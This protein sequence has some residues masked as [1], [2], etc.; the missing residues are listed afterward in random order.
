MKFRITTFCSILLFFFHSSILAQNTNYSDS[1]KRVDSLL[2]KGL[3]RSALD[4]VNDIRSQ[5]ISEE[6]SQQNIKALAEQIKLESI[7][8]EKSDSLAIRMLETEIDKAKSP[9]KQILSSLLASAYWNYYQN[10]RYQILNRT[11]LEEASTDFQT[12]DARTFQGE[13]ICLY[14]ESIKEKDAL[15]KLPVRDFE[16]IIEKAKDSELYR[17]SLYDLL[18]HKALDY[19]L[20]RQYGIIDPIETFD[21]DFEPLMVSAEDFQ[22]LNWDNPEK[23]AREIRTFGLFQELIAEHKGKNDKAFIDVEL[24]RLKYIKNHATGDEGEKEAAFKKELEALAKVAPKEAITGE[25]LFEIASLK[26]N[27]GSK[28]NADEGED[29]RWEKKEALE[30]CEKIIQDYP[31]TYGGSQAENLK[32]SI[33]RP[34]L[35]LSMEEVYFPN[36]PL[37]A[38]IRYKNPESVCFR[39]VELS[40][41]LSNTRN[42][43]NY[44]KKLLK[45]GRSV[46]NWSIALKNE[47]DYQD[48]STEIAIDELKNGRYVLLA[49]FSDKFELD[50]DLIQ[51]Q[52]FQVSGIAYF[53]QSGIE[54][55]KQGMYIRDR[56][57]GAALSGAKLQVYE[58][59]R[60]AEKM[61][62]RG[63][64]LTA[65]KEGFVAFDFQE[66]YGRAQYIIKHKKD[67]LYS[68]KMYRYRGRPYGEERARQVIHFFTDRKIYRPGQTIYFKAIAMESMRNSHMLKKNHSLEIKFNDVNGQ[69]IK[70]LSLK[71]N[72]F[73]SVQGSFT[74]PN[75]GLTGRMSI[76]TDG[77]YTDL[78]VEEYK[79]PKFEVTFDP[80]EGEYSLND[81]VEVKGF[82]KAFAGSNIDGAKVSYRVVRGANFPYWY[83]GWRGGRMYPRFGSEKEIT[84]G[85]TETD[86]EGKFSIS[87]TAEADKKID[88][89]FLPVFYYRLYADVVDISGE[90]HSAQAYVQV[91]YTSLDLS[92]TVSEVVWQG[93]ADS[94]QIN[95]V[96]HNGSPLSAKGTLTI[97]QLEAPKQIFRTRKWPAPDQPIMS[98]AEFTKNFPNT[99]YK[100]EDQVQSWPKTELKTRELDLEGMTQV[101]IDDL[102]QGAKNGKYEVV[103]TVKDPSGEELKLQRFFSYEDPEDKT[104]SVP[105]VLDAS[106]ENKAY[107]PG[108]TAVLNLQS[109]VKRLWVL[110]EVTQGG[111]VLQRDYIRLKGKKGEKIDIVLKEEH[112][113]GLGV[114]VYAI[115]NNEFKS[116]R[117]NISIPWTNKQLK[118]S[119]TTFRSKLSPGQEEEWRLKIS[120]PKGEKVAA[121]MV[122]SLYDE[123]LDEFRS[124]YFG[125]S[126]YGSN[127]SSAAWNV[128][129]GFAW[130]NSYRISDLP[131]PP[132]KYYNARDYDRLI[133]I[134]AFGYG[135]GGRMMMK[136]RA[137]GARS[138][139]NDQDLPVA[140]M[141]APSRE[142]ETISAPA[143]DADKYR[144]SENADFDGTLDLYEK[145]GEDD[146]TQAEETGAKPTSEV[147]IRTNLQETAF[148]FPQL[149]TNAEGE[150]VLSFKIPEALTRWKFLGLA[151]T[152]DLKV[153]TIGGNTVTQKE[154]MVFPNMPRFLREGDKLA[155]TAKISNLSEKALSGNAEVRL[156]DAL[157]MQPVESYFDLNTKVQKFEVKEGQS[158]VV[159][160]EIEVPEN[161]QAVVTQV[162]AS[163]GEFSDGEENVL[164]ILKN[165]MLVTESLPLAV[166]GE[167]QK[168]YTFKKLANSGASET[169]K[170]HNLTLEFSSNPAWYAVQ[171]LPYLMEYPHECTEQIFSRFY[172]NALATHVANSS[173]R[174]QQIFNQWKLDAQKLSKD[175]GALL[176][177]LEKNQEL[178]AVLLEETP[179]VLNA[180][181]ESERKRRIGLLFDLNRMQSE[182]AKANKQLEERQNG[183][184]AFSWFP[185]MRDSRYITQLIV[186]GIGHMD[187]L[188]VNSG[189]PEINGI[190][191]RGLAYLDNTIREDYQNLK[192]HK[193][194]LEEDHLG[195]TQIQ[196]LYARSFYP[197]VPV[198]P[199]NVEAYNYYAGQAKK[200]WLS[201]S[202]Y[203][204]GMLALFNFRSGDPKVSGDIL[205]SLKENAVFNEELGMYWKDATSGWYW[206]QAPIERH[207]LLLEAFQEAG[208]DEEAVEELK[209]WLLKNKQTND[210]KTT[211]ATVAAIN[212]LLSSGTDWLESSELVEIV[213]GG[214]NIDP[215]TRP[216][217]QV[218][219][220]TGYFMTSWA[221]Q[222]INAE[223]ATISLNKK[224]KGIAWGAMYWQ[225]FEQLDKITFAETPLSLKKQL[226][227]K[228][229][230]PEGPK[231]IAISDSSQIERGDKI[232]VRVE[233]RVD[234]AM[235]YVHMKDMRAAAFEPTET[236][237]RYKYKAGLGWYQSTRDV[238][239]HFFFDYLPKGT[240]VFEYD[241]VATQAGDFSNGI[242]S[243][244]S[245]YA[246]EFTSHSEGIRVQVK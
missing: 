194:N 57:T 36:A 72:D 78:S 74:A 237:S 192:K 145:G 176:S 165:S 9:E 169:L 6:N 201:K 162:I 33:E 199:K 25:V 19:L 184:G 45:E 239:T 23:L 37:L 84:N 144:D 30:L 125:M 4:L 137:V 10:N 151:H 99:V 91:A 17:P 212:A 27:L 141:P 203:M 152:K 113:G 206:Y 55:G 106:L 98:K 50:K 11:Q 188:G 121:E 232:T 178:K 166:R 97:N 14:E 100:D 89:K 243:I 58:E 136:S 216:D 172:A 233:L 179:W 223:K 43:S 175:Q 189:N 40:E 128:D 157:T 148:F 107:E 210:W 191:A 12:W 111:K 119:W 226:F 94:L 83:R 35:E 225:Y 245:M 88:R 96:N 202:K 39:I 93:K 185:G 132:R 164:P 114:G 193:A 34:S 134:S 73:G 122:A 222:E 230:S 208:K 204:Q 153:G 198:A 209:I 228:K 215:K 52:E 140:S 238:A 220:G 161:V 186:T 240:H 61:K 142:A 242:T 207:S 156:L 127:Y 139:M 138:R 219:A 115:Y 110:Y 81:E 79:R 146:M 180:R 168:T 158:T 18:A 51:H 65:N 44:Y 22:K 103:L 147:P 231:L 47:K 224:D 205:K 31:E 129:Y 69:E 200:F 95:T 241:L 126:L 21:F 190:G 170:H 143:A 20:T 133:A 54:A 8:Q 64:S 117:K 234:R 75:N 87:F 29:F 70:K 85:E 195:Y 149:E 181:S 86:I 124:N 67:V 41:K 38:K 236:L 229:N 68:S 177:N 235:E 154:L 82:A 183:N 214:E 196:Y 135:G 62:K 112:R 211:R 101:G 28:Y 213:V 244:Q 174:V 32:I 130:N 48:H 221:A 155:F 7:I 76:M 5:A 123:S 16:A 150:V 66:Q 46:R 105:V 109:S 26:A 217:A 13:I 53:L 56:E 71:T 102:L 182:F 218:E 60:R 15:Q 171:S 163:A 187:K 90:T 116:E 77:G 1:W 92:M 63:P 167:E 227:L 108:Q 173:P 80:V 120:G 104:P 131:Y 159:S 197:N 24:K 59:S 3:T 2:N 42:Q 49:S 160:W 118:L 246:P